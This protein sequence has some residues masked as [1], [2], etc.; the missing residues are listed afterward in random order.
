MEPTTQKRPGGVTQ[1]W[2][3]LGKLADQKGQEGAQGMNRRKEK[4]EMCLITKGVQHHKGGP[5]VGLNKASRK[6]CSF[7]EKVQ[8]RMGAFCHDKGTWQSSVGSGSLTGTAAPYWVPQKDKKKT[9]TACL[10]H[11]R[12]KNGKNIVYSTKQGGDPR[13]G[14]IDKWGG[15]GLG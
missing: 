9:S 5:E 4:K 11:G 15:G 10:C 13:G 12:K 3:Y 1:I 8:E 14:G 7:R 6:A 2:E